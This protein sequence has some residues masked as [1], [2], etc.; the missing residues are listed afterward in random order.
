MSRP[1]PETKLALK[2]RDAARAKY[3]SR[4]VVIKIHG[5]EYARNGVSD[6]IVCLD[7]VYVA[8]EIKSPEATTHKRKTL[9]ASIAHALEQGP[10]AKQRAFVL[11]VLKSGGCAGFAATVEQYMEI[12]TH[13]AQRAEDGATEIEKCGGHNV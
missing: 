3:G 12:L 6:H 10:T 13:A 5:N 11:S 9:E 4:Y 8:I 7:G 1:G 2:M